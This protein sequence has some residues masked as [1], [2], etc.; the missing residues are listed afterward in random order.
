MKISLEWVR[1]FVDLEILQ[2]SPAEWARELS[3][4]GFAVEE[5]ETMDQDLILDLDITTNR[6][7][8]L[9]HL[10]L[11]REIAAHFGLKLRKPDCS[12][13]EASGPT[14]PT[15]VT[16]ECGKL[17][18]RYACRVLTDIHVTTSPDWLKSRLESVGQRPVNNIVDITNYVLLDL[19]QPLHAFDYDKLREKRIVVRRA[20]KGENLVT[21][22]GLSR[23]LD[24]SMLVI[25][26]AERPI[27]LAGIM[28]GEKSA[29]SPESRSTLLESAYFDPSTVRR[30]A[31][32]LAMSTEAS[33]RF[34][35]GAD[36]EMPVLALNRAC[37]LMREIIGATCGGP[38]IDE[39]PQP[40]VRS[41]IRL[42]SSRINQLLGHLPDPQFSRDVL[43]RLEFS[44]VE[45][46]KVWRVQVP[47]FRTDVELEED[48]VEELA[49]HWGYDQIVNTYP[50][51]T[52]SARFLPTR[53]YDL[54]L[55]RTLVGMGF[56]EAISY[57]FS[58]QQREAGFWGK[59][60]AMIAIA[61][62]LTSEHTHLRIS[63]LP[64]LLEAVKR[65]LNR[66]NNDI[67]LFELGKVFRPGLSPGVEDFREETQ[68]ALVVTGEFYR[69]FWSDQ[70]DDFLFLH[71]KG[72]LSELLRK[73]GLEVEFKRTTQIP[74]LHPGMAARIT[75]EGKKMGFLGSIHPQQAQAYKFRQEVLV[76]ELNV[77]VIYRRVFPQPRFRPFSPFPVVERDLSFVLDKQTE[78]NK[79]EEQIKSL[80]IE[81]LQDIRVIDLYSGSGL[82]DDR[83]AVT[84]RLTF[85]SDGRTLTQEEAT[86]HCDR[87]LSLLRSTVQAVPRS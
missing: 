25:C 7:D 69:P 23:E 81:E 61:N 74:F 35:R 1:D 59:P 38:P 66:R 5:I 62:P 10:G 37:H 63:L 64:G 39:Y 6:P 16:I 41:T 20:M 29:V 3:M 47:S 84:M 44:V 68:L 51:P 13:P 11:A 2:L 21:L 46:E 26:D 43:R 56:L 82:P 75:F 31:K 79:L 78:Y 14:L 45:E 50:P 86:F 58:N 33:Y 55:T 80:N 52:Q 27:A 53:N 40:V 57:V 22:D 28:G 54:L 49:R 65:N 67:R 19:G 17:C 83:I 87:I 73:V 32:T 42:R 60:A 24:I 9:N 30:T 18:P 36:P 12:V 85:G 15:G 77:D 72:I 70:G 48:L 34:E 8:C 4:M 71:L 76:A